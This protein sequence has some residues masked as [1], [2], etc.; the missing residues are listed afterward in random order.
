MELSLIGT[1]VTYDLTKSPSV[2]DRKKGAHLISKG[3]LPHS[4]GYVH[5]LDSSG[6]IISRRSSTGRIYLP[7]EAIL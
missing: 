2:F 7:L 6:V 1:E 5:E 4:I 3:E